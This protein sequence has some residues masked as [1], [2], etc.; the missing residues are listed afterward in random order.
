MLNNCNISSYKGKRTED[1]IPMDRPRLFIDDYCTLEDMGGGR[2]ISDLIKEHPV[3]GKAFVDDK[4]ARYRSGVTVHQM[5]YAKSFYCM[6][7]SLLGNTELRAGHRFMI[8]RIHGEKM[9]VMKG[10]AN[11]RNFVY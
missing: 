8:G 1:L 3:A 6:R 5:L 7:C 11:L 4:F 2:I 9:A 10:F